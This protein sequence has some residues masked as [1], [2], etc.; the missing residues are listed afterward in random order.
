MEN[1]FKSASKIA[2]LLLIVTAC[3]GF[4]MDKLPVEQFMIITVGACAFYWSNK[5]TPGEEYLGK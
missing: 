2:F 4:L 1:I 5:G 3:A